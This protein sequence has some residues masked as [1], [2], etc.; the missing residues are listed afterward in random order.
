VGSKGSLYPLKADDSKEEQ[1]EAAF[2][3]T[4]NNLGRVD[5]LQGYPQTVL[6]TVG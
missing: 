4:K 2:S 6:S 5:V 3:W 1:V